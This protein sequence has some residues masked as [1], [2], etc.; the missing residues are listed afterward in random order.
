M[1][2]TNASKPPNGIT[3]LRNS[4][5]Q[6]C[7]FHRT[8]DMLSIK[9]FTLACCGIWIGGTGFAMLNFWCES[10]GISNYVATLLAH[11]IVPIFFLVGIAVAAFFSWLLYKKTRITL[12]PT[13][14]RVERQL[15]P[16]GR[17]AQYEKSTITRFSV[18]QDGGKGRD[19]FLSY[20]VYAQ[21]TNSAATLFAR[22]PRSGRLAVRCVKPVVR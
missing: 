20:A 10:D 18:A 5:N 11:A 14:L 4:Q 3:L 8:L 7:I 16:F 22:Q 9:L 13:V 6:T 1:Y 12:T 15:G 21:Q 2:P 19:S 17:T